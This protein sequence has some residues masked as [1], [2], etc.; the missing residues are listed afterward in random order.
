MEITFEIVEKV[1]YRFISTNLFLFLLYLQKLNKANFGNI[2]KN[3][4]F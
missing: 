3:I 1:I 4:T 2:R